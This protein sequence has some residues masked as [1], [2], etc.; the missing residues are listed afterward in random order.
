MK[1]IMKQFLIAGSLVAVNLPA[2]AV[3]IEFDYTYDTSGF[4]DNQSRRDMMDMAASFYSNFTDNLTAITPDQQNS[5]TLDF[6][7]PSNIATWVSV[8]NATVAEDSIR[9]YV[10]ASAM[11]DGVLGYSAGAYVSVDGTAEFE[12]T[13][14]TRGQLNTVGDYATDFGTWG[15]V[16][17]FNSDANWH[18][19]ETTDGLNSSNSDFLTTATHELGHIFGIGEADSWF[20]QIEGLS[21]YGANSMAAY[22]AVYSNGGPVPLA[23]IAHWEEGL[24]SY[25]N[26]ELQE[27]MMDPST[28]RGERQLPTDLDYAGFADVGWQ[29]SA[30]PEPSTLAMFALGLGLLGL[31]FKKS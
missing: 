30:V 29:V 19:G 31:R 7:N 2:Q 27:S 11:G 8:D 6:R 12:N 24:M 1:L 10:G 14:N 4:F 26:G 3:Q 17:A 5:W 9:V 21:F 15:G 18:F 13:I 25:Y 23:N 20:A 16:V 22:E 28:P